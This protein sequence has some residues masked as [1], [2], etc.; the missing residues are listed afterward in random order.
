VQ[1]PA[2]APLGELSTAAQRHRLSRRSRHT[3]GREPSDEEHTKRSAALPPRSPFALTNPKAQSHHCILGF[4][5]SDPL[6]E[7]TRT[8]NQHGERVNVSQLARRASCRTFFTVLT[9]FLV[10]LCVVCV[11]LIATILPSTPR[12]HI[13]TT[14]FCGDNRSVNTVPCMHSTLFCILIDRHE[15]RLTF[16]FRSALCSPAG[17]PA[18]P[19]L[20][21]GLSQARLPQ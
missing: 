15:T 7:T 16:V 10:L 5:L 8:E 1:E 4:Y 9:P 20:V 3:P 13:Y 21:C 12:K 11:H 18:S 14:R 2:R 6:L 17:S 19:D